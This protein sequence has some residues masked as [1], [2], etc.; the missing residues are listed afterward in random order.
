MRRG[1][2]AKPTIFKG[3]RAQPLTELLHRIFRICQD[4][5]L[6]RTTQWRIKLLKKKQ[7]TRQGIMI[8]ISNLGRLTTTATIKIRTIRTNQ[9]TKKEDNIKI[10]RRALRTTCGAKH[11]L[12]SHLVLVTNYTT[13]LKLRSDEAHSAQR[14]PYNPYTDRPTTSFESVN[15]T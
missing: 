15:L 11:P 4:H 7:G 9:S 5:I 12:Q 1:T 3:K 2:G 6:L 13:H 10:K 14:Y 8:P